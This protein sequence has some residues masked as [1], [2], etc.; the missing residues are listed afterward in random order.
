M[1]SF[2]FLNHVLS[3]ET[4]HSQYNKSGA[5]IMITF[6]RVDVC[7]KMVY[8]PQP[9]ENMHMLIEKPCTV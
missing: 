7:S 3:I 5:F 2:F 8:T 6:N 4:D 9:T 1:F